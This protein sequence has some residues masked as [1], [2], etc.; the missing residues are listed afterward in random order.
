MQDDRSPLSSGESGDESSDIESPKPSGANNIQMSE[1]RSI[2]RQLIQQSHQHQEDSKSLNNMSSVIY[3]AA[4]LANL[5]QEMLLGLVQAG[6]LQVH[7]EE[8]T[9]HNYFNILIFDG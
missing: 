4:A 2:N 3:S 7:Q 5:P 8:G 6:H 9:Y 1:G